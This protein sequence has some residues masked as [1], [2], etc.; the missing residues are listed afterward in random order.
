MAEWENAGITLQASLNESDNHPEIINAN[1]EQAENDKEIAYSIYQLKQLW[2]QARVSDINMFKNYLRELSE[3]KEKKH[4][5]AIAKLILSGYEKEK[6]VSMLD[7]II[8]EYDDQ[9]IVETALMNKFLFY[10][11]ELKDYDKAINVMD[12]IGLKYPDSPVYAEAK[13]HFRVLNLSNGFEKEETKIILSNQKKLAASDEICLGDNYPN[14]FN[15]TTTIRYQILQDGHISLKIYD[16]LGR[17]VAELVNENKKAG[18]YTVNF[19]GSKLSSGVYIYKLLGNNVNI[20]K[21]MI[22]MK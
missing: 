6:K 20:S 7:E 2:Y 9:P 10:F 16:M 3:K 22:L 17:E 14:P 11:N 13:D 8:V 1:I 18:D 15:P 21:K 4:L 19:D 5:S 12:Y